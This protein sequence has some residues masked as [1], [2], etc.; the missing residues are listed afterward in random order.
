MIF[1]LEAIRFAIRRGRI[2]WQS[3][4]LERMAQRGI[5]RAEVKEVL[6]KGE[7]IE[8]YPKDYPLPSALFLGRA[9]GRPL[10]AVAAFNSESGVVYIITAYEPGLDRFEPDLKTRRMK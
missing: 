5:L 6:L 9:K 8:E 1:N 7:I 2:E 3:H 10:H 4:A